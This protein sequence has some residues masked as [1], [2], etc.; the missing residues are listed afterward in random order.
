MVG[1]GVSSNG[2]PVSVNTDGQIDVFTTGAG[3]SA[4]GIEAFQDASSSNAPV[5]VTA[6]GAVSSRQ[7][8]SFSLGAGIWAFNRS[9]GTGAVTVGGSGTVTGTNGNGIEATADGVG[10]PGV[11]IVTVTG[12]GAS[13]S[14]AGGFGILTQATNA[15]AVGNVLVDRSG[16]VT[17]AV[18]GIS[19]TNAGTGNVTVTNTGPV[20]GGSGVG[21]EAVSHGGNIVVSPASSVIGTTGII[22]E[23]LEPPVIIEA[24]SLTGR[25]IS[26]TTVGNITGTEGEGV[27]ARVVGG[28]AISIDNRGSI[29]ATDGIV[30]NALTGG[31]IG[32]TNQGAINAGFDGI[33][34]FGAD[35]ITITNNGAITAANDGIAAFSRSGAVNV[36]NDGT[37]TATGPVSEGTAT[38]IAASNG[39]GTV[40]VTNNGT[41]TAEGNGITASTDAGAITVTNNGTITNP[42]TTAGGDGIDVQTFEGGAITVT[43]NGTIDVVGNGIAADGSLGDAVTITNNGAIIADAASIIATS[44]LG[45][46]TIANTGDIFGSDANTAAVIARSALSQISITNTGRIFGATAAID[47]AVLPPGPGLPVLPGLG[48]LTI[49]NSGLITSQNDLA[50]TTSGIVPATIDN[51]PGGIIRGFVNLSTP[52]NV[53]NNSGTFEAR[54]ASSFAGPSDIFNNFGLLSLAPTVAPASGPTSVSFV[55][56]GQFNNAGTIS[57]VNGITGDTLTLG[58]NY[59]G[60][61]SS[62]LAVDVNTAGPTP[63]ADILAITGNANGVTAVS[64]NPVTPGQTAFITTP[65][66]VVTVTGTAPPGTFV[67]A[68]LGSGFFTFDVTQVGQT[69]FLT[70]SPTA[71]AAQLPAIGTAVQNVFQAST[72]TYQ[73][74]ITDLRA[75]LERSRAGVPIF[76]GLSSSVPDAA[77]TALV[78]KDKGVVHT[79]PPAPPMTPSLRPAVWARAFGDVLEQDGNVNGTFGGRAFSFGTDFRQSTFGFQVGLDGVYS[80]LTSPDDG[81]I[82]GALAG[83]LGSTV[84][85]KNS[86]TSADIDGPTI[87][88]YGSYLRGPLFVDLMLKADFLN[89]DFE[90]LVARQSIDARNYGVVF[91]TGYKFQVT[92]AFYVEPV[93]GADYVHT[94]FDRAFPI[95]GIAVGLDDADAFLGRVGARVGTV[96]TTGDLRIEPSLLVNLWHNFSDDAAATFTSGPIALPLANDSAKTYVELSPSVNA[97]NLRSGVSGFVRAELRLGDDLVGGGVKAGL[98]YQW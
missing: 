21:I 86:P 4:I 10:I 11:N 58:G 92:D 38:G 51:Q 45:Q 93:I 41:I 79:A 53:I 71:A 46:I 32:I 1:I 14:N 72:A 3:D 80:G 67:G 5:F 90:P 18:G 76:A 23:S 24:E 88:V 15:G 70:T 63:S 8:N 30:A 98:R 78:S 36:T 13:I 52:G 35:N 94:D 77:F 74:R 54:G 55:N 31:S 61:G 47:A 22:A 57:L 96:F 42:T 95:G 12:T 60:L 83:Y 19:A 84:D 97:F 17:G 81:F 25:T 49:T 91:S 56:L 28:G 43:N 26:V 39:S 44:P 69:F 75:Q 33:E 50:I 65:V 59:T 16:A 62:K 7:S 66:P 89:V 9:I 29:R 82:V 68:P 64:A 48:S 40:N 2:G 37:I 87:G 73:E 20:Q 34:A 27:F 6:N 85:F